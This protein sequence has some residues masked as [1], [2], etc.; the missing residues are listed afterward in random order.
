MNR[1][2][3]FV[4]NRSEEEQKIF[5]EALATILNTV[6]QIDGWQ[7]IDIIDLINSVT[8]DKEKNECKNSS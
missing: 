4:K 6:T 5:R 3:E 2:E 1:C 7:D 8:S